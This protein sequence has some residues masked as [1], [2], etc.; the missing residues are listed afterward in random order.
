MKNNNKSYKLLW[1]IKV[2]IVYF[3]SCLF[4]LYQPHFTI[5]HNSKDWALILF[6][7]GFFI[8][9]IAGCFYLKKVMVSAVAGYIIGFMC[10]IIFNKDGLDSGGGKTNNWWII[11]T[12][13]FLAIIMTGI[14]WEIIDKRIKSKGHNK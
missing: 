14:I 11:W 7:F 2:L 10:G 4:L 13:P 6:L 12:I 5:F 8:I 3:I 1:T 9:L